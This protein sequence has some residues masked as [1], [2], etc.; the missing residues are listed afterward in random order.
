M[1]SDSLARLA[2]VEAKVFASPVL[3][4][5]EPIRERPEPRERG[6]VAYWKGYERSGGTYTLGTDWEPQFYDGSAT[7]YNYGVPTAMGEIMIWQP[8]SSRGAMLVLMFHSDV[9]KTVNAFLD[10]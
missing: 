2:A 1:E 6:G 4:S 7:I 5:Q 9:A 8:S 3:S 10:A